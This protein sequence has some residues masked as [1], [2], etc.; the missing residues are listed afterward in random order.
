MSH[1]YVKEPGGRESKLLS[2]ILALLLGGEYLWEHNGWH[3]VYRCN[4]KHA[5]EHLLSAL[6]STV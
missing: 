6:Q 1:T 4:A 2:P 3:C 5:V